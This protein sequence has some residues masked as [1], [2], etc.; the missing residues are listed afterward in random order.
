M[1]PR[2]GSNRCRVAAILLER[3]GEKRIRPNLA[4]ASR[5]GPKNERTPCVYMVERQR[6][7]NSVSSFAEG[8]EAASLAYQARDISS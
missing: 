2:S 1:T 8:G 6:M 4:V 5:H 3:C 7:R